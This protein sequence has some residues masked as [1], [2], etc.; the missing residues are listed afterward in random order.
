MKAAVIHEHGELEVL[1]VEEVPEPQPGPDEVVV[2]VLGAGLNHLDIWVRKGR[3][4]TELKMSH[5][6]GSDA[7]GVVAAVGTS[8]TSPS[9]GDEVILNPALSCGRCEFCARGEHS[10]CPSFGLIGLDR[11][12]T[13]A[14]QVAVPAG[15]VHP[16][17]AHLSVEEAATLSLTFVTAWRML[18]SRA[19]VRPGESVLIHGIGGGVALAALQWAKRIGAEVVVTSSSDE[20]LAR[21]AEMGADHTINYTQED[22]VERVRT[23]TSG[24]RVDVV[25]DSVG[26]ATWGLNFGVVRRG[27]R[28]AT[29][30]VTTGPKAETNLQALYWNQVRVL[31]STMGSAEDYRQMLR[32]VTVNQLRPVVDAVFPLDEAPQAMAKME[33][34]TQFGKIAL[35]VSQ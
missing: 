31:G 22:V 21:A 33:G 10:E 12:G 24:R 34:G 11:A 19:C 6:L 35:R 17:P 13:F 4:G 20:K 23:I 15:N 8:V 2:K 5:V 18:M 28:I 29:C 30:G 25:V 27:G 32:A 9:V 26:A 14:E 3:P 7:V 16:K 1:R